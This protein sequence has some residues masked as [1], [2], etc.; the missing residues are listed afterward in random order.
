MKLRIRQRLSIKAATKWGKRW[1]LQ[2]FQPFFQGLAGD[3]ADATIV[4]E[5]GEDIESDVF[6]GVRDNAHHGANFFL[7]TEV[8]DS[9]DVGDTVDIH[10]FE[11]RHV[12]Q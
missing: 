2:E 9:F 8:H 5:K 4:M 7:I 12:S 6:A 11:V 1:L 3:D 10:G